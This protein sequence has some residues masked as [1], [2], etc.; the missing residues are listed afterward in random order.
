MDK[1]ASDLFEAFYSRFILRDFMAKIVPGSI[2]IISILIATTN[3]FTEIDV[4][5]R[6]S[7]WAW[8]IFIGISWLFGIAIQ[9]MGEFFRF[10]AK[11]KGG[12]KKTF[13]RRQWFT[14]YFNS[15]EYIENKKPEYGY[16]KRELERLI[17]LREASGNGFGALVIFFLNMIIKVLIK[18]PGDIFLIN[19]YVE[20]IRPMIPLFF[21]TLILIPSIYFFYRES[22]N[23]Q[24]E[25]MIR[26]SK[27]SST[28]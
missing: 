23:A 9:G 16:L 27:K 13:T 25:F 7:F 21:I 6:L 24:Y 26:Y 4:L 2:V 18:F 8:I 17:F 12:L 5:I 20:T 19:R 1:Q 22:V 15:K 11:D 14:L 3:D 10:K 28:T